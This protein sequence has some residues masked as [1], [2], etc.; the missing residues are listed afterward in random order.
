MSSRAGCLYGG[1]QFSS[2]KAFAN[3]ATAQA[4]SKD[5]PPPTADVVKVQPEST[6]A[7]AASTEATKPSAAETSATAKASAG[8]SFYSPAL[9]A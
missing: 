2:S 6:P 8:I 7:Q 1:I 9:K 4:P 3:P 5:V